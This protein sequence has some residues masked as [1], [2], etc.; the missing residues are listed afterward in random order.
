MPHAHISAAIA[1]GNMFEII[2]TFK[3]E[4]WYIVRARSI[5]KAEQLI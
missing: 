3:A 4:R 5:E 1:L 2:T